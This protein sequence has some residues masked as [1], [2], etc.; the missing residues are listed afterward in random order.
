MEASPNTVLDLLPPGTIES[1]TQ[2][3][4]G[5]HLGPTVTTPFATGHVDDEVT[6]A[7]GVLDSRVVTSVGASARWETVDHPLRDEGRMGTNPGLT[8]IEIF[9]RVLFLVFPFHVFLFVQGRVPPDVEE[10]IGPGAATHEEGSEVKA[11][12]ILRDDEVDGRGQSVALERAGQSIDVGGREGMGDVER[13][14][15]V[16]IAVGDAGQSIEDVRLK[17][18]GRLHDEGM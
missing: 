10:T 9:E 14:V 16:D 13:V 17:R 11:A 15:G 12:A 7:L 4:I 1:M 3:T 18:I 8:L 6:I 2:L 5:I